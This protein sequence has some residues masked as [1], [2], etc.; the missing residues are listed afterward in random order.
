MEMGERRPA[1]HPVSKPGR[2]LP[3]AI[4]VRSGAMI[5]V[6]LVSALP[7]HAAAP[8]SARALD[9]AFRAA[10]E[11]VVMEVE[12]PHCTGY[13]PSF[14]IYRSPFADPVVVALSTPG[15][16]RERAAVALALQPEDSARYV[17]TELPW[18]VRRI[19][20][21]RMRDPAT[22]DWVAIETPLDEPFPGVPGTYTAAEVW[23]AL[24]ESWWERRL[25][26][27]VVLQGGTASVRRVEVEVVSGATVREVLIALGSAVAAA[28]P[29]EELHWGGFWNGAHSAAD[30][31]AGNRDPAVVLS[32]LLNVDVWS[33]PR[34]VMPE[35][36]D[37]E[38]YWP[39]VPTP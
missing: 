4:P 32:F 17:M 12:P 13:V 14:D 39:T 5:V 16:L 3:R 35:P 31:A 36:F 10:G 23:A 21:A 26:R 38:N 7:G 9:L 22:C 11:R 30:R 24:S 8:D 33:P 6:A 28:R 29:G 19:A 34:P 37:Y 1:G 20:A 27:R 15:A 25:D 18:G 2:G